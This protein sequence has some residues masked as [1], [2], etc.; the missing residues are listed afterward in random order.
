VSDFELSDP[1]SGGDSSCFRLQ[2]E[3][4]VFDGIGGSRLRA[5]T[6]SVEGTTTRS[7]GMGFDSSWAGSG[8]PISFP[9]SEKSTVSTSSPSFIDK[10]SMSLSVASGLCFAAVVGGGGG[11]GGG[12]A[13]VL[14]ESVC[15]T[16]ESVVGCCRRENDGRVDVPSLGVPPRE[17]VLSHVGLVISGVGVGGI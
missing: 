12:A 1:G 5:S 10:E 11:G 8:T 3:V 6:K 15:D 13:C 16:T 4:S 9:K 2:V 17:G 7:G 14:H